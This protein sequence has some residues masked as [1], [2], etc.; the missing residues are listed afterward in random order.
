MDII[1]NYNLKAGV[2][3]FY[4]K[5]LDRMF[6]C[7]SEGKRNPAGGS[8][9]MRWEHTKSPEDCEDI[10]KAAFVTANDF[11]SKLL[12]EREAPSLMAAW[13]KVTC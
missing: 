3:S 6:T 11:F 9:C 7:D 5:E 8:Q 1:C 4:F 13:T 2:F 12:A 10:P